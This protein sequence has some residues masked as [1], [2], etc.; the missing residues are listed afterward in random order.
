MSKAIET[1]QE[2]RERFLNKRKKISV[3]YAELVSYKISKNCKDIMKLYK[4]SVIAGF[5]P[6][7]NEINTLPL[8]KEFISLG[9]KTCLPITPLE[10]KILKFREWSPETKLIKGKYG[11][12]EPNQDYGI[13]E[14]DMLLVPLLA[15]DGSGN[16]L[17][18]GGGY[19][20]RTLRSLISTKKSITSIGVAFKIQKFKKLPTDTFD[21]P[22]DAIID[23]D[24]LRNFRI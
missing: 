18:Y 10:D 23:E 15:Y 1:K 19:Y 14:P 24:G 5:Y 9:L 12:L 11:I 17:G 20:D 8:L 16:R 13:V 3:Q 2:I 6:F 22:L 7:R 4:G 21:I